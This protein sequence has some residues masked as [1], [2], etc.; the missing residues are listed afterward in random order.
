MEAEEVHGMQSRKSSTALNN[1]SKRSDSLTS[2][3]YV[4]VGMASKLFFASSKKVSPVPE[5]ERKSFAN[6]ERLHSEDTF[7]IQTHKTEE[8]SSI[9][10][11]LLKSKPKPNTHQ[12]KSSDSISENVYME[13]EEVHGMQSRKS[14]TALNNPSKRSDSLTSQGYVDVG[15]ASK[16]FFASSKKV[17]P[18]PEEERKPFANDE[19]LHSDDSFHIQTHKTEEISSI[20]QPLLKSKPKPNT[21]Q[22]KSSDSISENVYMEAEEVHGM[23]SRKSSTALNNPSK[24]SDSLTSQGYVDVGMAS[25][26][27]FASSKKV[28]PVPQEERKPFANDERLHSEDTFHIQTHKTEEISSIK[29]PLLKSK[30]KPNTHQRKSSDSISENVYMEAEEVHGMQSRK[31]STALN[32]LSKRSDSLTS[33]GYVDVG[34]ASKLFF[35]SS[36][37]VSP[38][39]EEERKPFANNERLHSEDTF[40]IQTHKTEEISSIK[41][42]LLKSKPKPNTHQRKSSDSISENVY[43]EAEEVHGMQSRKSS[44]ALNNP[45]KRSDSLTSQGYVDVGMASKLF[46]ASSK[47]VSPVPEEERKPFANDERLHSDDTFHI[48]THKT[49]EISSIKQPLLK[50]KPKPNT[51]QRK[52]SDSISENVYMEAE[53]VHGMQSRKSSTALNN[54]S[55]RS[56]S[57][58]S[59]GYVDVGMVS[60]L[61]FASSKKVSPVHE[62]E[63]KSFAND[64][65]LHSEDTFHIQTHKTEEISSI[66]QP[67]LKSKPT[68]NTHQRKS[69][70]SISENVYMEAEEVHGMQSRKSSTA[71]NNPSKRSDS[72]TSQGY[73]DVGMASKLFFASSK[74]VSPVP[75]EERKPFANDERLHSEDTFHIQTHKT[76]EISSI[77]QPLLKSKPKT[78]THQRKSSDSI[79]ENVYMEAEEVHGMQSRKSSTALNNPSKRSDSLTSQGYVDVG[80]ASKLFFAS[81]KKVSPVP[82]EER[83]PFAND[84]R[85]HSDDSFHIQTHKTEEISSIKQPLLKSK[86]KPNTHQ[87]KSSDSISENVY[88]EAEEVHGM[89]S[90]K[91]STALN[92]PSKR[93]DSLTSQGYVDVGMASKLFFASSKKVSPV[94]E[95]ERKPFANDERLHSDDTFHIQTDKTEE[96]SSIKQPLLKSKSTPNTHQ[97]KSS[98][99]IS[100]NVYM[101]AEEVHGMQSRKSSTA[102]NNPSKRSDS[103]TSQG[104]VDV[105]MASKLFFA[106][107]KKVSPVPEEERKSFADNGDDNSTNENCY[108]YVDLEQLRVNL[109]TQN[110][111][112]A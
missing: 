86:P 71:L 14:S 77:K 58:T 59:Q 32:N 84:E 11:P 81:S 47:K 99:S 16:L 27:F 64:E 51:H 103:L 75:E 4:D 63:R 73:V 12:R 110:T 42:P 39:P 65:R 2:Q 106:S 46:F 107:S 88:M 54:P 31:S 55:K 9:K 10:Q 36:K 28:S 69:S 6:D 76:E 101:E 82:E 22:R 66:K 1:P 83:K 60:K 23:Q 5:E 26:L 91:S 105:G 79:S 8:I 44:T 92:N 37:K 48:Q 49:E 72:L 56:D 109:K 94:P 57:L 111:S 41:Q 62:E 61:F 96:I 97:R 104:Y 93:S 7:H 112:S 19:R 85:L 70:D 87:R 21:H 30:P 53:E 35:A 40:H 102:L 90:R 89:Q 17:S 80:M 34:M 74:K 33:Q 50:S 43:M 25:K 78:N 18:V 108:S 38:V 24:R 13:A 68:P 67:L 45:S 95:E 20:K 3:G 100:E 52:S 29:Q 98:D 15:M